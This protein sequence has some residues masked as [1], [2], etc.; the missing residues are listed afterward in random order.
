MADSTWKNKICNPAQLGGI[1]TSVMDNGP[2]RGTRVAWINTGTGLRYKVVIDRAMDIAEAFYNQH[3]LAWLSHLGITPPEPF[4]DKGIDWIRTFGGG[5]LITCGLTHV[6]GPEA[7]AYGERGLHGQISNT[8]AEIESIIQPDPIAG[9]MEM[10]ITGRIKQTQLFGPNLELRR[11]ISGRVGE[12]SIRIHDEV[13]NRGNTP[14]PHMLLYHFNFGWPLVDEG[15]DIIWQGAWES[16]EGEPNNKIFQEGNNFRKCSAPLE[17][18]T[19]G[20]EEAAFI[21]VTPDNAGVCVCGLYN[22]QIGVAL[23]LRFQ[24]KQLPWLTNWQHWGRGE[25]VTGLEPGTNPPIGQAKAREQNEL[26]HLSPGES[27]TYDLEIE[28]F[29]NEKSINDFLKH[30]LS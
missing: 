4:S 8:P 2:G 7:D 27:R 18:H 22:A 5:L 6:G 10:S 19:G 24:K 11:T 15:T 29:N 13:L 30:N 23:A 16:R 14:A 1:E 25:Y 9:K 20:G 21:D 17:E 12:A 28:V 3:S 26:I